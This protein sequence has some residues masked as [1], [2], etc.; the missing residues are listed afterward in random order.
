MYDLSEKAK[1]PMQSLRARVSV[2]ESLL[3]TLAKAVRVHQ[4]ST[5]TVLRNIQLMLNRA[6]K[7]K[8]S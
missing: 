4:E 7:K 1:D 5:D 2:L 6:R 3:D 8:E